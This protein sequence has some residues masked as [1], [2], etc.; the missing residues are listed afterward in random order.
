MSRLSRLIGALVA[1][2][3]VAS[4]AIGGCLPTAQ[5]R[6]GAAAK[7][8]SER[9]AA[10]MLE[11]YSTRS[12][13]LTSPA[14][15][16]RIAAMMSGP[17]AAVTAGRLKIDDF[18]KTGG[19]APGPYGRAAFWRPGKT[20]GAPWFVASAARS[21]ST[22]H[23]LLLFTRT[24]AGKPF[25][26]AYVIGLDR[27]TAMPRVRDGGGVEAVAPSDD[28]L[29][30]RPDALATMHANIEQY[31]P[32]TPAA[33]TFE[34]S[35]WTTGVHTTVRDDSRT[36]RTSGYAYRRSYHDSGYPVYALRTASGG[37]LVWYAVSD[38]LAV[39]KVDPSIARAPL[40]L[41]KSLAGVV[42]VRRVRR[43]FQ[44]VSVR[45]YVAYVPPRG[46][47][48]VRVLASAGG[49]VGGVGR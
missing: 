27:G 23:D 44:A 4:I 19:A 46:R 11:Q 42:G 29:A 38:D 6:V 49:P 31:G 25:T 1:L 36:A 47:G 20:A 35:V 9:E 12:R 26:A 48:K 14:D 17:I 8:A 33:R 34:P 13:E 24:A 41:T 7:P 32:A 3:V 5:E 37:A 45:Q 15:Q 2:G 39:T 10:R 21:G 43:Q 28:R 18:Q 30:V 22:A 40:K 16:S